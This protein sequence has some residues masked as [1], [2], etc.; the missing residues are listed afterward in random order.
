MP[1]IGYFLSSDEIPDM[2]ERINTIYGDNVQMSVTKPMKRIVTPLEEFR[3][4]DLEN[5]NIEC[6]T[7][8]VSI[9]SVVI[10]TA[11][12]KL[13]NKEW[14]NRIYVCME[15]GTSKGLIPISWSD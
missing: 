14:R 13:L 5:D 12:M 11:G 4:F 9:D 6:V 7:C 1:T 2:M 3:F 8:G 10:S 15:N